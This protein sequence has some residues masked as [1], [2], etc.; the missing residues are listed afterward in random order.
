[1][2]TG[3]PV[4]QAA[5]PWAETRRI[6]AGLTSADSEALFEQFVYLREQGFEHTQMGDGRMRRRIERPGP[7][8]TR[9]EY[10]QRYP[11]ASCWRA[12]CHDSNFE[13]PW[14]PTAAACLAFA[15]VENWGR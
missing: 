7:G 1:M 12:N 14:L 11:Y 5:D 10:I 3:K 2:E 4:G 6:V 13:S 9:Y 15:E 8:P